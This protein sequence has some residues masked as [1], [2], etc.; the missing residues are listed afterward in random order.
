MNAG[1]FQI[2]GWITLFSAFFTIPFVIVAFAVAFWPDNRALEALNRMLYVV[3]SALGIYI[4]LTLRRLLHAYRFAAAD[5]VIS[6]QISGLVVMT[7]LEVGGELVAPRELVDAMLLAFGIVLALLLTLLGY[8]VLPA[9][10]LVQGPLATYAYLSMAT[11]V[12]FATLILIPIGLMT[13]I[14]ESIYLAI[15]F[16]RNSETAAAASSVTSD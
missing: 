1:A 14:A 3:N 7:L 10:P 12:C 6:L 13:G 11:G 15:V 16:F 2:A 4:L 5:L 8:K 9:V